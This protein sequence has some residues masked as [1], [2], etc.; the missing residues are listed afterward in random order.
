MRHRLPGASDFAGCV[1]NCYLRYVLD[2]R[3]TQTCI[4]LAYSTGSGLAGCLD[5]VHVPAG[6]LWV[7]WPQRAQTTALQQ[8]WATDDSPA[9]RTGRA[10][11]WIRS[12]PGGRAGQIRM[13]FS[14]PLHPDE[15]L[16]TALQ[17]RFDFE[18]GASASCSAERLFEGEQVRVLCAS[19]PELADVLACVSFGLDEGWLAYYRDVLP[20]AAGRQAAAR[21]L[22]GNVAFDFPLLVALLLLLTIKAPLPQ[23]RTDLAV[24]N[25][26][27]G[28][29]GRCPL[30]EHIEL[31]APV[32]PPDAARDSGRR[33]WLRRAPRLH[34]VRGHLVRRGTVLFWRAPHWR[35]HARLG[36][37]RSRTVKLTEAHRPP[38]VFTSS[39]LR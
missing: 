14:D 18:R 19:Q 20:D 7:E 25:A 26:K 3:L 15:A 11:A 10:G 6:E 36:V 38:E 29:L 24:L 8:I 34:Q 30:L 31:S 5:L 4:A 16:V 9:A 33:E 28:R 35:G 32:S 23:A 17:M 22:L 2:E 27:R 12:E 39:A 37:I 13:F 1:R 21:E